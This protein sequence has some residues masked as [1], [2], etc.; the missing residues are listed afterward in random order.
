M[1]CPPDPP[2]CS[3]IPPA[4]TRNLK[5]PILT[6][7]ERKFGKGRGQ[8]L[9][10]PNTGALVSKVK[11]EGD[12]CESASMLQP[13]RETHGSEEDGS[14]EQWLPRCDAT[15]DTLALASGHLAKS[16]EHDCSAS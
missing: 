13:D 4:S 9:Q 14:F 16:I 10:Q 7:R 11:N 8:L 12:M 15:M 2:F 5:C 1:D 3:H 6:P